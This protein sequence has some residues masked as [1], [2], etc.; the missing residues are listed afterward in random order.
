MVGRC[1]MLVAA[2]GSAISLRSL[3]KEK[4]QA[5]LDVAYLHF[6]KVINH[7]GIQCSQQKFTVGSLSLV[8]SQHVTAVTK[9][10]ACVLACCHVRT[11][12]YHVCKSLLSCVCK[13]LCVYRCRHMCT[14]LFRGS[15]ALRLQGSKPTQEQWNYTH[16]QHRLVQEQV[17]TAVRARLSHGGGAQQLVCLQ[18]AEEGEKLRDHGQRRRRLFGAFAQSNGTNRRRRPQSLQQRRK[19]EAD[20][21]RR[22][23]TGLH[24]TARARAAGKATAARRTWSARRTST[25]AAADKRGTSTP[26]RTRTERSR[27]VDPESGGAGAA[28]SA[29]SSGALAGSQ[30]CS[31]QGQEERGGASTGRNGE[32]A[33]VQEDSMGKWAKVALKV[34]ASVVCARTIERW[35]ALFVCPS[36]EH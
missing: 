20:A 24:R 30:R 18:G 13:S 12:Q 5:Q 6:G 7:V 15:K 9:G 32:R 35:L 17:R 11:S 28:S 31:K 36:D 25:R 8:K 3:Q 34:H 21:R 14:S 10:K 4:L 33:W 29:Q 26:R 23:E 27:S 16:Q 1:A 19:Q 22:R 2:D